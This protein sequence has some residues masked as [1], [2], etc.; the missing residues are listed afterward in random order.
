M[1]VNAMAQT[2]GIATGMQRL[3]E[4]DKFTYLSSVFAQNGDAEVDVKCHIGKAAA[5]FQKKNTIWSSPKISL[6]IKLHLF[7]TFSLFW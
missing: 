5:A 7:S 1:Q 6:K 3:E 4:V 2:R